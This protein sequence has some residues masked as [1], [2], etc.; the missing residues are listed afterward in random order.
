MDLFSLLCWWFSIDFFPFSLLFFRLNVSTLMIN[1][2]IFLKGKW[3]ME[4]NFLKRNLRL[5]LP[6]VD[7]KN[8]KKQPSKLKWS[9]GADGVLYTPYLSSGLKES[10]RLPSGT[11]C[12]LRRLSLSPACSFISVRKTLSWSPPPPKPLPYPTTV[13]VVFRLH[14]FSLHNCRSNQ[15]SSLILHNHYFFSPYQ[16]AEIILT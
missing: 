3:S 6:P 1:L 5:W 2:W 15:Y 4:A 8:F 9:T 10:N 12:M 16:S 14:N 13:V 7:G 11:Y